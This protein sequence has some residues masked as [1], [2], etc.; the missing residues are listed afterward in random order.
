MTP[1][2][3]LWALLWLLTPSARAEL[4]P[5][6][7]VSPSWQQAHVHVPSTFFTKSVDEVQTTA[8]MPVVIFMHGCSGIGDHER[9]WAYFLKSEGFI[10]VMPDSLALPGRVS[11]CDVATHTANVGKVPVRELRP[12]EVVHAHAQVLQQPWADRSN[13]FL[14]GHSEGGMAAY[15][16]PELGFRGVIISGFVCSIPGG[17]R[18]KQDTPVLTINW[19][20]D[21]WSDRGGPSPKPCSQRPFWRL[22]TQATELVL[23]GRGHATAYE[24]SAREAVRQ[25]LLEHRQKAMP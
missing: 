13:I 14:M 19:Q 8:P 2:R 3:V 20:S 11:N 1:G 24:A 7:D 9:R 21:P 22:R 4:V 23:P 12:A 18:A 6:H 5:G 15:L 16:T 17:I 25:F 10:V